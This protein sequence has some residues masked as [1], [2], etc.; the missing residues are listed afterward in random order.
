M[1]L[2][3]CAAHTHFSPSLHRRLSLNLSMLFVIVICYFLWLVFGSD[4]IWSVLV[5]SGMKSQQRI[6]SVMCFV[7]QI[8]SLLNYIRHTKGSNEPFVMFFQIFK[9]ALTLPL[10]YLPLYPVGSFIYLF[11]CS[12]VNYTFSF[13]AILTNLDTHVAHWVLLDC[14]QS[15]KLS[16]D[17]GNDK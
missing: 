2:P 3:I 7:F 4:L 17:M 15:A 5:S 11:V 16:F 14:K 6:H 12:K 9:R 1:Y 10:T 8:S 13:G